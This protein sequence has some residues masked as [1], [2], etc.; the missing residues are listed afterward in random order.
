M[1]EPPRADVKGQRVLLVEDDYLIATDLAASLE[2]L[3]IEVL[4]PAGSVQDALE[5]VES[6][7]ERLDAA[8]LDIN[9][10]DEGVY[11]VANALAARGVRFV[12][13]TGYDAIAIPESFAS[14]PRCEKPVDPRQLARWLFESKA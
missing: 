13:T 5:L 14:V 8:V 3:G 12:F 6:H 11:P 9:L 1:S 7:G 2:D 10:R 4:G